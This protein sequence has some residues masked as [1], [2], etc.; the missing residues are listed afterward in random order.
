MLG[1]SVADKISLDDSRKTDRGPIVKVKAVF[2]L[3][4]GDAKRI[5]GSYGL[6]VKGLKAH[7]DGEVF[8]IYLADFSDCRVKF[9]PQFSGW[10]EFVNPDDRKLWEDFMK[11]KAE[12]AKLGK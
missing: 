11:K 5:V 8:D 2:N 1:A 3:R 6:S 10:M 12:A 4:G 7:K 9:H